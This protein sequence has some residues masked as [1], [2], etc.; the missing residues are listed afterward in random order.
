MC[1]SL[2][3]LSLRALAGVLPLFYCMG[4]VVAALEAYQ[5]TKAT[6][7]H[8]WDVHMVAARLLAKIL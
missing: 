5:S 3:L 7:P 1:S 4:H 8:G 6:L 2:L